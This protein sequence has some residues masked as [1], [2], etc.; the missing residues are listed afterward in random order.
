MHSVVKILSDDGGEIRQSPVWCLVDPT[1][2]QGSSTYCTKEFFGPGESGC[3]YKTKTVERGGISCPEC[4]RY[5]KVM[6]AIK[7]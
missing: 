7:L 4:L 3:T 2:P 6:K 5:I 1:N